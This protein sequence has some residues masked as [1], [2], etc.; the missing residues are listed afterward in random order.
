MQE[1]AFANMDVKIL[2][3]PTIGETVFQNIKQ[4]ILEGKLLPGQRLKVRELAA[5]LGFSEMPI[6]DSL[7]RL[8]S[9]GV[10]TNKPHAGYVVR[11]WSVN[12]V[13]EMYELREMGEGLAAKLSAERATEKQIQSCK[14]ILDE[15]AKNVS[16]Y[17]ECTDEKQRL[18]I[19]EKV[20]RLDVKFHRAILIMSGN[21]QLNQIFSII[22]DREFIVLG[23]YAI[24]KRHV[25][26]DIS[27]LFL[28]KHRN[29][30]QL[31]ENKDAE[32]AEKAVRNHIANA[33][34]GILKF[35]SENPKL[36]LKR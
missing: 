18:A 15:M 5:Q 8:E 19:S 26:G 22:T 27:D 1:T 14:E 10:V 34:A 32:G 12:D 2:E 25:L 20:E 3:V 35:L 30:L 24:D 6:R 13:R 21:K 9:H 29:M 4:R 36:S 31:I 33:R 16:L 23:A 28:E 7:L 17:K 11:E